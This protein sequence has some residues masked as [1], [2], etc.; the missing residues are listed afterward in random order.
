MTSGQRNLLL[1]L[2]LGLAA[3]IAWGG[4][5]VIARTGTLA[6]FSPIDLA[7]LRFATAGLLLAPF[8]WSGR[9]GLARLGPW[10]LLALAC[11][12]GFG[13]ALLFGWGVVHAPASHGGTVAPITAA[14]TGALFAIPLLGEWPTRGRVVALAALCAGLLL[15]GWDGI[16][17]SHPGAWRGDLLLIAAGSVWGGFTVLLRRWQVPVLAGNAANFCLSAVIVLIPWLA[18]GGGA[19]FDLPWQSSVLQ[20]V[21]QGIVSSVIATTLYAR[22]VALLGATRAACVGTMMPVAATVL[23]V[24]VLG[25]P[26]APLQVAGVALAVG[27][28]LA[29]VLFTGRTTTR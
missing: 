11:C 18:L 21:G 2:V 25:E 27:A 6:G 9:L 1:G 8:A 26:W 16:A 5:A 17:G 10:R 24:L 23:S 7:V 14:V 3:A 22:G 4:Q 19:V 13:N 15:I 12:G 28:M 20:M 29:A